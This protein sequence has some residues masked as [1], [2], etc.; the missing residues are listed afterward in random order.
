VLSSS[1]LARVKSWVLLFRLCDNILP[2]FRLGLLEIVPGIVVCGLSTKE[3]E[4]REKDA[5][6]DA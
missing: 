4:L 2:A 5:G 1:C 6:D 3:V